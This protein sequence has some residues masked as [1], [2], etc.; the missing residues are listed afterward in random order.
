MSKR[1]NSD[2][3]TSAASTP[4]FV[5][6]NSGQRENLDDVART[7]AHTNRP[8]TEATEPTEIETA[9]IRQHDQ[10]HERKAEDVNTVINERA[11][12]YRQ[13][14]QR[15]P[16]VADLEHHVHQAETQAEVELASNP[17]VARLRKDERSALRTLRIFVREN[18]LKRDAQ[19]PESSWAHYGIVCVIAVIELVG[20]AIFFA[21]GS[22]IGFAGGLM[23]AVM[24]VA[25]NV[26]L[27]FFVGKAVV[28]NR[29]HIESARRFRANALL[30][31]YLLV[32]VGVNLM[33]AHYRDLALAQQTIGGDVAGKLIRSPFD[34]TFHSIL[35]FMLGVLA[36][37]LT[38]WK[39]YL[40]DDKYPHY[41]MY[42]RRHRAALDAYEATK[43][44]M[45]TRLLDRTQAIPALCDDTV[46]R[47]AEA[48]EQMEREQLTAQEALD[49]YDTARQHL[50]HSC[51]VHLR[52]F[53]DENSGV[54]TT[55]PP[56]YFNEFPSLLDL[57]NRAEVQS[58]AQ[59]L[60]FHRRHLAELKAA[61]AMVKAEGARR[62]AELASRFDRFI[63]DHCQRVEVQ[64][65]HE[66]RLGEEPEFTAAKEVK[67]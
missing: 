55:D 29:N 46:Q 16:S 35:L 58:M 28:P 42:F 15:L 48:I 65:K 64:T 32:V 5:V 27:G 14:E 37:V 33:V 38:T 7:L 60:Q 12:S 43:A 63:D 2:N 17:E 8:E 23:L 54:R 53:R 50:E 39:S 49:G 57:A 44:A 22:A 36:A 62:I 25:F 9:V 59:R 6:T 11:S 21:E 10:D 45:L 20:N 34:L 31:L 47:T 66:E 26:G 52:C 4:F 51:E 40:S 30:T 19:F 56:A 61:A 13:I 1:T 24:L 41:G 18:R 67:A 3:P